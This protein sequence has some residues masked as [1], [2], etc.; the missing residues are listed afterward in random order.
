METLT[1]IVISL[2]VWRISSLLVEEDGPYQI[3]G[4]LRHRVGIRYNAQSEKVATNEL[5][6]L[7]TCVWC[8]S[9]WIGL[10]FGVLTWFLPAVAFW[11]SVPLAFSAVAIAVNRYTNG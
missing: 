1:F 5:A 7:F 6:E 9:I 10:A 4:K 3:F 11:I 8:M 2:A